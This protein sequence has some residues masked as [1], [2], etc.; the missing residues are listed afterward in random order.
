MQLKFSMNCPKKVTIKK[1]YY[2]NNENIKIRSLVDA[3]SCKDIGLK[4][5]NERELLTL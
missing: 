2:Y 4:I 1:S 5:F 3:N